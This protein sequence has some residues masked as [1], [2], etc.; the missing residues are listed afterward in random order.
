MMSPRFQMVTGQDLADGFA[1]DGFDQAR[2]D[3]FAADFLAVPLR[4]RAADGVGKLTG[5]LHDVDRH[6]GGKSWACV[7]GPAGR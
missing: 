1:A 6:F 7:R 3:D 4:E 2:S 5:K